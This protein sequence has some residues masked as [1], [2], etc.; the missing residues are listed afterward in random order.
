MALCCA[1]AVPCGRD[2]NGMPFGLQVIGPRGHDRRV[3]EVALALEDV[4]AGNAETR[5]PVPDLAKLQAVASPRKPAA[6]AA[7]AKR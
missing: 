6:K 7:K 4:L 1:V 5:R 2:E 3:L